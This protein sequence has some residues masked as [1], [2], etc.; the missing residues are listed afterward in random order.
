MANFT[1]D[2]A[3]TQTLGEGSYDLQKRSVGDLLEHRG[4]SAPASTSDAKKI[5]HYQI[6]RYTVRAGDTA[7]FY[8]DGV[9]VNADPVV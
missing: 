2:T 9:I 5:D 8:G 6:I 7:Y 4:T 3:W 1:T